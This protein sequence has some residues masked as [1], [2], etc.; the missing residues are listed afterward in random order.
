MTSANTSP[1]TIDIVSDVVCP[2]CFLGK[3]RLEA[4]LAELPEIETVIR[5]RPY[6]LDPSVPPEGV[7]RDE[8]IAKRFGDS[9][10]FEAAQQN[11]TEMGQREG[12]PYRF[13]LIKRSPNTIDAHRLIRWAGSIGREAEAVER[14]FTLY[15]VEGADVGSH[16]V[17]AD[18]GAEL[19]LDRDATLARLASDEDRDVVRAEIASSQRIG[20]T[21]V[22]TFILIGRYGV[23]GAQSKEVLVESIR[24]AAAEAAS[25]AEASA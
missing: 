19:G 4:A 1:V 10:R 17:L 13:D 24:R 7:D 22:P 14:L 9:S 3:R 21:G 11:L 5:W 2:W 18:V 15:F 20:V 6:Q 25:A 12:A 8:Y 23:V 16:D